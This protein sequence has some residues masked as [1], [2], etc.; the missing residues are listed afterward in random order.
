MPLPRTLVLSAAAILVAALV[1]VAFAATSGGSKA[2]L[3]TVNVTARDG[4][5]ALSVKTAPLGTVRFVVRNAGTRPHSFRIAG[6]KT[7]ALARGKTARL[8]VAFKRAGKYPYVST[9]AGD[10]RRGLKGTFRLTAPKP[11]TPGNAKAGRSVFV[12]NCGSCHVLKA[13]GTRGTIGPNLDRTKLAY[14]TIHRVV[15]NGK[16]GTAMPG[17]RA[18]LSAKQIRD[19]SAFVFASTH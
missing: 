18:T 5:F 9:V 17:F 3:K 6:K 11:S 2:K 8:T 15:T 19:V 7:P 14:A 4:G 10:V 12:A 13:A 16:T 1:P